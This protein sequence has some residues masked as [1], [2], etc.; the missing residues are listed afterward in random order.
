MVSSS[1]E[2]EG[3]AE[4]AELEGSGD[5]LCDAEGSV[6]SDGRSEAAMPMVDV[7]TVEEGVL[8]HYK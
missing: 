6:A 3:Q 8:K 2:G 4:R 1:F 5:L 7:F